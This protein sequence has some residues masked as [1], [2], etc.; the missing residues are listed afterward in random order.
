MK[1][2]DEVLRWCPYTMTYKK[3]VVKKLWESRKGG[4]TTKW[5][6]TMPCGIFDMVDTF[7]N[8]V[9]RKYRMETQAEFYEG[10]SNP[11]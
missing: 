2:G 8:G 9:Q 5:M 7:E 10:W 1:I 3:G 11:D 4:V 6:S